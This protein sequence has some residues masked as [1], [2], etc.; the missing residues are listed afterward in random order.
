MPWCSDTSRFLTRLIFQ[1]ILDEIVDIDLVLNF[2]CADNCF[3]KKW[4]GGDICSHCGQLFDVNS[5]VSRERNFSLGS[6]TWHG[7]AQQAAMPIIGLENSRLEKMRAYAKQVF[8]S[9]DQT[10]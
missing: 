1:E 4:S 7:Q 9:F 8:F 5:P 10:F 6:S 2:K 3:M